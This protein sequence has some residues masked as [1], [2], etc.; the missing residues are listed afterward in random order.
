VR[1]AP[2]RKPRRVI[3]EIACPFSFIRLLLECG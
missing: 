2:R 3:A 1:D